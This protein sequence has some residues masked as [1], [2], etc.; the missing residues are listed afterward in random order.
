M[1]WKAKFRQHSHWSTR[2]PVTPQQLIQL[3]EVL[4]LHGHHNSSVQFRRFESFCIRTFTLLLRSGLSIRIG[5]KGGKTKKT[6]QGVR[7]HSSYSLVLH[8]LNGCYIS[9]YT[10]HT[11]TPHSF[12]FM[13][14]IPPLN[15]LSPSFFFR[16]LSRSYPLYSEVLSPPLSP[17]P[18]GTNPLIPLTIN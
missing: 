16:T 17:F 11:H 14:L 12:T 4:S 2:S 9:L 3:A 5:E 18:Q 6:Y 8:L 7:L 13:H 10:F 15:L 1:N